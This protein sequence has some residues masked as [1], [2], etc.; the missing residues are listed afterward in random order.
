[1][2]LFGPAARAVGAS[3]IELNVQALPTL[4]L[5]RSRLSVESPALEP[6]LSAGRFAVNQRYVSDETEVSE[7]D[8]IA[9][10]AMVSGG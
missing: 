5:I 3:S 1:M 4:A 10:I 2:L 9:L 8:E 7:C 6:F